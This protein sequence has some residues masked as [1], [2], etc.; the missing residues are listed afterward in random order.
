MSFVIIGNSTAA[1][2]AVEGIRRYDKHTPITIISDEPY[3]TY[4]RPLIS[5]YLGGKT[6]EENMLY[7]SKDFYEKNNVKTML[8]VKAESVDFK[9]KEVILQDGSRIPYSKLLIATGAKP[10][11]PPME[12]LGKE[13]IFNF[14]KFDDVKK[15]EKVAVKGSK[16]GRAHV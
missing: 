4:S 7:R 15:I 1:I 5:Y 9:K 8:G 6:T 14:I 10:F 13:N 3:H 11:V 2:G 12:G 16:I